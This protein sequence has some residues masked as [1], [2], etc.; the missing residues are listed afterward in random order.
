MQTIKKYFTSSLLF[1]LISVLFT[2]VLGYFS[3]PEAGW[4]VAIAFIISTLVL[5]V[6]ETSVSLDNAVVNAKYIGHLNE[7]SKRWFLTWGM[8]IAVFGMRLILPIA[9]VSLAAWVDPWTALMLA[10]FDPVQYQATMESVHIPVVGF[11][12]GFLLM[13]ALEFFVNGEKDHHWIPGLENAAAYLGKFPSVQ[14]LIGLP[15]CFIVAH[16]APHDPQVLLYS[17]VGGVLLFYAIHGLKE[18]LETIERERAAKVVGS[19]T[20]LMV[21]AL[22]FLEVLDASF[23]FDGVIAAFAI[24]NQFLVIAAGLGI[25]A[26]FVRSFT[27]YLVDQGTMAKLQ[28]LEHG[29]FYGIAWLVAA[30]FMSAY[31]YHIGEVI[32]AGVAAGVILAAG[33]HSWLSGKKG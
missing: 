29:A 25:G 4:N 21:G 12:A 30:M 17:S 32:V 20:G 15:I 5:G 3:G 18:L 1:V 7:A 8:V 9:I 23:S 13:V 11:G 14:L 33:L 28:Y 31:G 22:V 27:I 10:L 6:L 2:G 16:F 19:T 26:M 24:T